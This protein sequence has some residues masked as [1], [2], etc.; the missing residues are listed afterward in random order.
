[1]GTLELLE[2]RKWLDEAKEQG[3][4]AWLFNQQEDTW[5]CTM[6]EAQMEFYSMAPYTLAA[7]LEEVDT[8]QKQVHSAQQNGKE[9]AS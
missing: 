6:N 1:M 8:L 2:L 3:K 4:E 5:T 7:L 9:G